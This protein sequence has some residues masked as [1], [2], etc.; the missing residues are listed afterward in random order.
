MIKE[1]NEEYIV[2]FS[3]TIMD[4]TYS[5]LLSDPDAPHHNDIT[6]EIT[7]KVGAKKKNLYL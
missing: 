2:E 7:E 1:N 3:V 5:E 4:P 6:R